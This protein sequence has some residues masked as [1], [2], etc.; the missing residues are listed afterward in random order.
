MFSNLTKFY[1][2]INMVKYNF[3]FFFKFYIRS[4]FSYETNAAS[5]T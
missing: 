2:K 3:F 4:N 5:V 1:K